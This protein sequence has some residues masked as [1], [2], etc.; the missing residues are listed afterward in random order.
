MSS[1]IVAKFGGTPMGTAHGFRLA[2]ER[3]RKNSDM[4][5]VVVS[6]PGKINDSNDPAHALARSGRKV[7]DVLIGIAGKAK[8]SIPLEED[9]R[10][11]E[12]RYRDIESE[13]QIPDQKRVSGTV[14]DTLR[15]R[16]EMCNDGNPNAPVVALGEEFNA[17]LFS[18]YLNAIGIRAD[19]LDPR[20]AG[21]VVSDYLGTKYVR[22]DHYE[23]I[24]RRIQMALD[25]GRR[26]VVP[27]FFGYD[28]LGAIR[29][30]QRGGSDYTGSVLAAA[31]QAGLYQNFTDRD[32]IQ[33]VEPSIDPDAPV[34]RLATHREL[35]ELTLGGAFGVFQYEAAVPL[36]TNRV[37]A[38]ILDAF[39][40]TSTGTY[41]LPQTG[42]RNNA[43]TGIVHRGEFVAFEIVRYGV[44][45]EVG[46]F[47]GVLDMFGDLGISIEHAPS[48]TNDISI[49]VRKRSIEEA[50]LTIERIVKRI[51]DTFSPHDL[52]IHELSAVAI[53]GEGINNALGLGKEVF[54][55][56]ATAGVNIPYHNH[57]GITFMLWLHNGDAL[58]AAKALYQRFF[59][60]N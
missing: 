13:L 8:S 56:V 28:D 58:K 34:M 14:G 49:I 39:D 47:A 59:P 21:I 46:P 53:V 18:A 43:V 38:Q 23:E 17:R 44:A 41:I 30:F 32:G 51:R 36:A 27:G 22:A 3:I 2:S 4:R 29:T 54:E 24:R 42:D 11:V 31:L 60:K 55:A 40:Q 25:E 5:V 45:N 35:A 26:V 16:L 7:T 10:V 9:I 50:G 37:S 6:A 19:Y 48:S 57:A 20:D 12:N 15:S 52:K 33:V 1:L